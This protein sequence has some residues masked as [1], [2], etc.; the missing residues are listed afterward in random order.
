MTFEALPDYIARIFYDALGY[1]GNNYYFRITQ[2]G[3]NKIWDNVSEVLSHDTTWANSA[4]SM[5]DSKSNGQYPVIIPTA[6]TPGG[7]Y[8]ISIYKRAASSPVNTDDVQD[9]FEL[10]HGSI[11][12]F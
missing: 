3:S 2:R 7:T 4:I 6:L 8:E 12:G 5:T 1:T 9:T 10:V 11:F